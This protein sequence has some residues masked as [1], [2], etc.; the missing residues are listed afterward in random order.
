MVEATQTEW[1]DLAITCP[2]CGN[3]GE[4]DGLW[5]ANGWTP[6]RLVEE[7]VRS[8]IF[9]AQRD[10]GGTLVLTA[11]ASNDKVDWENGTNLRLECVTCFGMFALPQEAK[12]EFV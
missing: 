6:F 2:H 1:T 7:V 4:E 9:E 12:V 3:H 5:M 11:D 8:W 10:D